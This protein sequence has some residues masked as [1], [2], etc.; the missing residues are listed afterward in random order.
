MKCPAGYE[1]PIVILFSIDGYKAEYLS[2]TNSPNIWKLATCG[3]HTPYMRS[4]TPTST[5]PNHYSMATGLYPESHGIVDNTMY[6]HEHEEKFSIGSPNS[7]HPFWWGGEPIWVTTSNQGLKSATYFWVGSDVNITRYP[8]YY[9]H[10]DSSV[11]NEERMYTALDWLDMSVPDRPSFIALYMDIVDHAGHSYGPDSPQVA[12]EVAE[13]DRIVGILMDGLKLRGLENCVNVIM[14]ADHGMTDISCDRKTSV[15]DYGVDLDLV[16]FKSGAFSHIGKSPDRTEWDQFDPQTTYDELRCKHNETHWLAYQKY[17]YLPKRYHY[18]NND[19]IDDI[20]LAMDDRWISEGRKGSYTSCNGGTHGYDNEYR[21]MHALFAAH[22]VAF[23]RKYETMLPFE[24]IELYNLVT[25]LLNL[26]AAPNNGTEGSLNHILQNPSPISSQAETE[27]PN[28]CDYPTQDTS[29]SDMGCSYCSG[30]DEATANKRLQA[31]AGNQEAQQSNMPYGRPQATEI[32]TDDVAYCLLTQEDYINAYDFKRKISRYVSFTMT[33]EARQLY[34][35]KYCVRPDI[36]VPAE[37]TTQ[38]SDYTATKLQSVVLYTPALSNDQA[39]FDATLTSN[40]VPMYNSAYETWTYM[41][42]VLADW[43][44]RYGGINVIA[45]PAFDS[46][47]DGHPDSLETLQANGTFLN[48]DTTSTPIPTHFFLVVTRCVNYDT[49]KISSC[50]TSPTNLEVQAFIIPNFAESP[51]NSMSNQPAS[52][53]VPNTLKEHVA[54]L[55][56]VEI[57]TGLSFLPIWTHAQN[58]DQET[59]IEATRLRL[60]LPQFDSQWMNDFLTIIPP[61]FA[62]FPP[63]ATTTNGNIA[64]RTTTMP[65]GEKIA[66]TTS[67]TTTLTATNLF[68]FVIISILCWLK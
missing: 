14:V 34:R 62:D 7:Y 37:A 55:R 22:G 50:V 54:R 68:Y 36:R 8:D 33:D 27:V 53:W 24:N 65:G 51:C 32:K 43:S 17:G 56:D 23:K 59:I 28:T 61:P 44:Q 29:A 63:A 67:G 48:D 10:F 21:S 1:D 47:F 11:P 4:V 2:K 45:G 25:G 20:V 58:V 15:E 6:D 64:D 35:P 52:D 57:L 5:F 39:L 46:D 41:A 26:D 60:R 30:I 40:S 66:E 38:C 31:V 12:A 18:T 49:E 19:R 42:R 16:F 3:V 13:A 9:Y